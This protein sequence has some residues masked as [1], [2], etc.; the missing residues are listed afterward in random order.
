MSRRRNTNTFV[1]NVRGPTSAL[2]SFLNE[3]GIRRANPAPAPAPRQPTTE[4]EDASASTSIATTPASASTSSAQPRSA[5]ARAAAAVAAASAGTSRSESQDIENMSVDD[6]DKDEAMVSAEEDS[7]DDDGLI[8]ISLPTRTTRATRARMSAAAAEQSQASSSKAPASASGS[9]SKKASAAAAARKKK[10]HDSS[11]SSDESSPENF[12]DITGY[13][14]RSNFSHKGRMPQGNNKIEFCSR[15]RARFTVKAGTTP[16]TDDS[17]VGLLCPTCSSTTSGLITPAP[18]AAKKSRRK[19]QKTAVECKVPSLQDLCIQKIAL[20]IEDVEAFGDISDLSMNKIC[21][22]I[23]RNRSLNT[24]T[25]QLFL[26]PRQTELNL[27]DCTDIE[28]SGLLNIAQFCPK[29]RFLNLIRCGRIQD[30]TIEYYAEHLTDLNAVNLSGPF[31]VTDSAFVKLFEAVGSR[32][33]R[34]SLEHSY[35]FSLQAVT[36]LCQSC[37]QLTRLDL[38]KCTQMDDEWLTPLASLTGLTHLG[39]SYPKDAGKGL[40]SEPMVKLLLAVGSGLLSLDLEGCLALEDIVLTEAIRPSC[41]RLERLNLAGCEEFTDEGMA[42]LFTD[43]KHNRGLNYLN[44]G[45]CVSLG[46]EA[47]KAVVNHSY[48]MLEDLSINSLE[49][50]TKESLGELARCEILVNL[51]ASWVRALDD[52]VMETLVQSN[53]KLAQVTVWGAHRLTECC[54]TRKG[55]RVIGREGDYAQKK[56][57]MSFV[58]EWDKLDDD[59]ALQIEGMIHA[60]FQRIPKPAFMGNIAVSK[61]RFGSTPPAITVLDVTDPLEEWYFH[62]DQ[63]EARLAQEALEAGGGESMDEDELASGEGDEDDDDAGGGGEYGG[64]FSFSTDGSIV[65]VGEGD[66]DIEYLQSGP[67]EEDERRETEEWLS[68]RLRTTTTKRGGRR[69][70]A[71]SVASHPRREAAT[72]G[73]ES[74]SDQEEHP[75]LQRQQQQQQ[76]QQQQLSDRHNQFKSAVASPTRTRGYHI[77]EASLHLTDHE[78]ELQEEEE[79]EQEEEMED[80]RRW[81]GDVMTK[82]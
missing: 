2:T 23:C 48:D 82:V 4:T 80:I 35:R 6:D 7:S 63:E 34:F 22:I 53:L 81:T 18:K 70:G 39:L 12:Q 49:E 10:K 19:I 51:D 32:F 25:V 29:I 61:F 24:A 20:C 30:A 42:A 73:G 60:H 36:S 77:I 31:T 52:D 41:V 57:R 3:R 56:K 5:R 79:E 74:G 33:R 27:Y 47:L 67:F 14:T 65:I 21:K 76:Q 40:T 46:D 44:L 13:V 58:F 59:V 75:P 71:S 69:S 43:W 17:G 68:N 8:L 11:S 1:N 38:G 45:K 26:D 16:A 62:M 55:M 64:E 78:Q 66:D 54:P 50:L 15:C 72:E 37:P 9:G 28:A